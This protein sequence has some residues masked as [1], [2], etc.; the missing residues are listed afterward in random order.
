MQIDES[1]IHVHR[2]WNGYSTAYVR[3]RDLQE[4]HWFQPLRAPRPLLHGYVS[5][6]SIVSGEILHDCNDADAPHRLFVCVLK[7]NTLPAAYAE[8]VQRA[9]TRRLPPSRGCASPLSA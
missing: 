6:T 2:E 1:L 9:G 4:I 5:C 3:L 8:L 7:K